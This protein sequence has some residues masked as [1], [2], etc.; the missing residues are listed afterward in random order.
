M[1]KK[2][3]ELGI[4]TAILIAM[5][6]ALTGCGN[7]SIEKNNGD[8]GNSS[9]GAKEV[10]L[11]PV[12][13]NES[14]KFGY[15]DN[16]GKWV[17]EPKYTSASGFDSETGLAKVWTSNKDYV[18]GFI[19]KKGELVIEDKYGHGTKSFCNGY[20]VVET[21][22]KGG[23]SNT[24][25]TYMLIDKNQNVIIESGKYTKMTDVSKN[26]LIGVVEESEMKYIKL[27]GTVAIEKKFGSN[28]SKFNDNGIAC[29][30]TGLLTNSYILIDE[31][32]NQVGEGKI[33]LNNNNYGFVEKD[34]YA[35]TNETGKLLSDAIYYSTSEF[36]NSNT[37]MVK[38]GDYYNP[39][40]LINNEGKKIND[41]AYKSYQ[42]L[43]DG[44]WV[45]TLEDGKHQV[46]NADGSILVDTF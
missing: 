39:W 12:K 4:V 7:N 11:Y 9:N 1:K 37:A 18:V 45:V 31:Q 41:T 44:K 28:G 25:N 21:N 17:I 23:S 27:D 14:G 34:H 26:G 35:I 38:E 15:V 22:V 5:L 19:N 16:N 32:G 6:L 42:L 43:L 3:L 20:A 30:E 33:T 13:D 46:L 40:Y 2:I 29:V 24:Y 8:G 10:E 36:N